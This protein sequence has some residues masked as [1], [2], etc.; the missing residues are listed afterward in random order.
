MVSQAGITNLDFNSSAINVE[1][2]IVFNPIA[3]KVRVGRDLLLGNECYLYLDP[4]YRSNDKR[5]V[6][7]GTVLEIERIEREELWEGS[8][9]VNFTNTPGLNN[10]PTNRYRYNRLR[11]NIFF[12]GVNMVHSMSCF[13]KRN[14]LR[15]N[16]DGSYAQDQEYYQI[17]VD[18]LNITLRKLKLVYS[19]SEIAIDIENAQD[20]PAL[21]Y[22]EFQ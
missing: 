15:F 4:N 5:V 11:Y 6:K 18:Q 21:R 22:W 10:S 13:G 9:N 19:S 2:D 20:L 16:D 3:T 7:G 1:S 8:T 17:S 14:K 12:S